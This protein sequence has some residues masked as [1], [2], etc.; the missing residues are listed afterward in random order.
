MRA[1]NTRTL[2]RC[3]LLH[4]VMIFKRQRPN[5][6]TFR[7]SY[8]TPSKLHEPLLSQYRAHCALRDIFTHV[9]GSQTYILGEWTHHH[10]TNTRKKPH[11]APPTLLR[12][13]AETRPPHCPP[14]PLHPLALRES[15][16]FPVL[17]SATASSALRGCSCTFPHAPFVT[18]RAL[19]SFPL[20]L[21]IPVFSHTTYL[22][23]CN[24]QE[25]CILSS[26]RPHHPHPRNY[27]PFPLAI[28][29]Q[30]ND[31][32]NPLHV[33]LALQTPVPT[34]PP[35]PHPNSCSPITCTNHTRPTSRASASGSWRSRAG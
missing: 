30:P 27:D 29:G 19:G 6:R 13:G 26:F 20:P 25:K 21:P 28:Y 22:H 33:F 11:M 16:P 32:G 34:D 12:L 18:F 4:E 15:R 14:T 9:R 17:P 2:N 1:E 35:P 7:T 31:T 5:S 3:T 10:P 23:S 24:P 8:S